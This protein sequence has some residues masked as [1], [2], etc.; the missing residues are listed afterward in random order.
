MWS[1]VCFF[2][3]ASKKNC[4]AFVTENPGDFE[5][6]VGELGRE[7]GV[8]PEL[9]MAAASAAPRDFTSG[10]GAAGAA[11]LTSAARYGVGVRQGGAA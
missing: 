3:T 7:G 5:V 11:G 10:L 2:C 9:K 1:F 8:L 6:G 4:A